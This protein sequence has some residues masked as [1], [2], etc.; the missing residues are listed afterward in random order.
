[1]TD[2]TSPAYRYDPDPIDEIIWNADIV[3][4]LNA[5]HERLPTHY[6]YKIVQNTTVDTLLISKTVPAGSLGPNGFIIAELAG[7]MWNN[8]GGTRSPVV[9]FGL[10]VTVT[11]ALLSIATGANAIPIRITF[12]LQNLNDEALQY[13]VVEQAYGT[14]PAPSGTHGAF[15][16]YGKWKESA[17]DTSAAN[18]M[19][20]SL[21]MDSAHA[22][23][24]FRMV[25]ARVVGPIWIA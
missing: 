1:M 20:V 12:R 25:A 4:N 5:L 19:T 6:P 10:G 18:D 14:T 22:T 24:I 9:Y 21:A 2:F 3:D 11:N 17:I 23:H 16:Y 7:I 8:S 13:T 15:T